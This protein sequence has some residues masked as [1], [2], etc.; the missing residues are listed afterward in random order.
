MGKGIISKGRI[1]FPAV[2]SALSYFYLFKFQFLGSGGM[3]AYLKYYHLT[4]LTS[5]STLPST[6]VDLDDNLRGERKSEEIY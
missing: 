1:G 4:Q 5:F 2:C 3:E 6:T